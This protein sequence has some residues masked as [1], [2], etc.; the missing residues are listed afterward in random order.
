MSRF[1]YAIFNIVALS[2]VIYIGIDVFYRVVSSQLK[3]VDTKQ[4]IMQQVPDAGDYNKLSLGGLMDITDRN[5][6]GS[7][8]DVPK[9]EK[10]EEIETLEPTSLKLALIGTV[11]G[12]KQNAFAVI[13]ETDKRKQG[14]YKMG[15]SINHAIVKMILREK[16]VL[17][18]GD[19]DEILTM[20]EPTSSKSAKRHPIQ[21]APGKGQK[22]TIK[23]SDL[24][25]S[26][27][28]INKLLAQ[29]RIRPHFK[30]GEPDGLAITRI[31]ADSIFAKFGLKNGDIVKAINN[32]PIHSPDEVISLYEKL[33]SGT[34]VSLQINRKG[35]LKTI[36]YE[37]R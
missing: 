16:V 26:L 7:I 30:D 37:F 27:K 21:L 2:V 36:N 3:S 8:V 1:Y 23:R 32:N 13:E 4:I 22:I 20:K 35:I 9:K 33:K 5:I 10:P 28:D 19:K 18:V 34:R 29:V 14:L 6:F 15:D 12:N 31:K 25:M 24:Q 11:T 17:R